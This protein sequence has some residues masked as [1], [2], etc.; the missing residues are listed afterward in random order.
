VNP[1]TTALE[2]LLGHLL[3]TPRAPR[4]DLISRFGLQA[5]NMA[6]TCNYMTKD[7]FSQCDLMDAG[8]SRLN[9]IKPSK[10]AAPRPETPVPQ[11]KEVSMPDAQ[12]ARPRRPGE[13]ADQILK[14][15]ESEEFTL[16]Q[17]SRR[18]DVTVDNLN[19]SMQKLIKK[20]RVSRAKSP[21]GF[22]YSLRRDD[23]STP[24]PTE[25]PTLE[26]K[27]GAKIEMHRRPRRSP[28]LK[29]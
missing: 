20:D 8:R 11:T 15:L 18:L 23:G 5:V 9:Q 22:V 16:P 28:C 27:N 14:A 12:P 7:F 21:Q 24:E 3:L 2:R 25:A 26:F 10:P 13:L 29:A 19:L 6:Q 1:T 4:D 17:L